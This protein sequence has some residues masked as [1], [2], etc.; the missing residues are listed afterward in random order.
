[1]VKFLD[2]GRRV[3]PGDLTAFAQRPAG[4]EFAGGPLVNAHCL[5][6]LSR[7]A[8][9]RAADLPAAQAARPRA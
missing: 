2:V 4:G 5:A 6:A 3:K 9:R 7:L 8:D 1:M